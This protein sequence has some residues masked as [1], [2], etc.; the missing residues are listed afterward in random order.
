[1]ANFFE[2]SKKTPSIPAGGTYTF[3]MTSVPETT[4]QG[5]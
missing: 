1:M 3:A 4:P 2:Y 5:V